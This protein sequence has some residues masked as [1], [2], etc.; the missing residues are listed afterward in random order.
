MRDQADNMGRE[1]RAILAETS[2]SPSGKLDVYVNFAHGDEDLPAVY[3][4]RKL[5]KLKSLV[6]KYDPDRLFSHFNNF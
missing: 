2:G 1:I 3:G 6:A 5:P 4:E